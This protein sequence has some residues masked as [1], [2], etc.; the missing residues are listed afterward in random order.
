MTEDVQG[1]DE[2]GMSLEDAIVG[3]RKRRHKEVEP[4]VTHEVT[5]E[6]EAPRIVVKEAAA[7]AQR[8]KL[9][10]RTLAEMEAGRKALE[11]YK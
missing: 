3:R 11:Q 9:S 5:E 1:K 10:A 8:R 4:E 2:P 6:A 7:P